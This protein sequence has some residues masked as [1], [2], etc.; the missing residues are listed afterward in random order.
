[1]PKMLLPDVN[2]WLAMAFDGHTHHPSAK[3][4]FDALAAD[5]CFFCRHSPGAMLHAPRAWA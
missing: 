1:M 4:W 2:V 5:V 3:S